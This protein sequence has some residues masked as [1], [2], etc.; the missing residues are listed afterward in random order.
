VTD[1]LHER[2]NKI[3]P[4]VISEEFIAGRGLGNEVA[5]HIFDYPPERELDVRGFI[6][7]LLEHIPMARPGTRVKAV[8]LFDFI[9]GHLEERRL[10]ERAV[11]LQRE[12]GDDAVK[13]ALKGPLDEEKLRGPF[14]KAVE[15]DR[16]DL[17]FLSGAGSAWPLLRVHSLLNNLHPVMGRTPLVVFYPGRYDG[18]SLRLFGKFKSN[19]Y[20]AFKLIP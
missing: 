12:K 1:A 10:L 8:D 15:P 3:L 2:L 5:F 4:R 14:V 20:R 11:R 9:L 16:H 17:V 19:Y 6:P 7:T 13:N 18:M